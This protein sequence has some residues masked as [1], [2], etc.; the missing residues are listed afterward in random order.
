MSDIRNPNIKPKITISI[1]DQSND[2][3]VIYKN[4]VRSKV[5]KSALSANVVVDPNLLNAELIWDDGSAWDDGYH[6][7]DT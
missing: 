7:D 5:V 6:W 1:G 4:A 2:R 3:A